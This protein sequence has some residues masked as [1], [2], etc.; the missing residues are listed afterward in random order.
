MLTK[1]CIK[2]LKC[3]QNMINKTYL[4]LI[5]TSDYCNSVLCHVINDVLTCPPPFPYS[6]LEHFCCKNFELALISSGLFYPQPHDS[7]NR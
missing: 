3:K 4:D 1:R 5:R 6:K 7:K 2:D